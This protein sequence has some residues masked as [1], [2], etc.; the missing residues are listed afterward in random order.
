MTG[1][2]PPLV[3]ITI[4]C[5]LIWRAGDGFMV[6][7]NYLGRRLSQ[8]VRGASINAVASSLPE[9]LT[10]FFFIFSLDDGFSGSIGTTAG[11]AVFNSMIIPS[12]AVLAVIFGGLAKEVE[13]PRKAMLR[14]G[15]ALLV[16]VVVF[17]VIVMQKELTWFH[18]LILVTIYVLY[19]ICL[20]RSIRRSPHVPENETV[21]SRLRE[22]KTERRLLTLLKGLL[23]LNLVAIVLRRNPIRSTSALALL[24]MSSGIM[25]AMC[26]LLV[27]ACQW[28][29][30]ETYE[31]PVLGSF[32][33]FNIPVIF[34]ALILAAAASSIPDT[35]ISVKDATDGKYD[36]ALSNAL[37]SNIFAICLALGLPLLIYTVINGPLVMDVQMA[38]QVVELVFLL[39]VLSVI[40]VIVFTTSAY[41]RK[42]SSFFLIACYSLFFL[43]IF[44]KSNGHPLAAE[45]SKVIAL[46]L[47]PLQTL[48]K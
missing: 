28:L 34:V 27:I 14:D 8:G 44:A 35:I 20:F 4:C 23:T 31:V 18:G 38:D 41:L 45:V 36:D 1:L 30:S 46:I 43:Y 12:A 3:L 6:G 33:G 9:L 10:S 24:L 40:A 37:G 11:S 48:L 15:I 25:A 13:V 42:S 16:T 5:L 19:L 7:S 21:V 47:D 17:L 39:L 32:D 29:G 26:Y 22:I 2:L